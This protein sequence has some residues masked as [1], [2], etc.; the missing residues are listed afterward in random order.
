M[1]Y[2][3]IAK[4]YRTKSKSWKNNVGLVHIDIFLVWMSG[5][6]YQTEK[7]MCLFNWMSSFNANSQFF[8][9]FMDMG[10]WV[11]FETVLIFS[12][13]MHYINQ[14]NCLIFNKYWLIIALLAKSILK[15][16]VTRGKPC[17]YD[18]T[19][20]RKLFRKLFFSCETKSCW[21]CQ[22]FKCAEHSVLYIW[23][24]FYIVWVCGDLIL[25]IK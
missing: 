12:V 25:Y 15:N 19:L 16:A 17:C 14:F 9:M 22:L 13:I 3:G 5:R 6:I 23:K 8:L 7:I 20:K 2:S 1:Q 24:Q 10:K 11:H 18:S 21:S 4:C